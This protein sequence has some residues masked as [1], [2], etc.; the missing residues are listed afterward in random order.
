MPIG[1]DWLD[2]RWEASLSRLS[3]PRP[4]LEQMAAD[5]GGATVLL[6][7][8][9]STIAGVAHQVMGA[10]IE[11]LL[12]GELRGLVIE[13]ALSQLAD[14][15]EAG[16]R[17]RFKLLDGATAEEEQRHW[18][19]LRLD[20][21]RQT[22]L[23]DVGFDSRGLG[24][25][26]EAVRRVPPEPGSVSAWARL[27]VPVRFMVGITQ[28]P[29]KTFDELKRR[30][31]IVLDESWIGPGAD[32]IVVNFG[33]RYAAAG[34]LGGRTITLTEDLEETMDEDEGQYVEADEGLGKLS[35]RLSFDLGERSI[36]LAE[37][38]QLGAGHVF[39]LGRDVRKAV[40]IRANGRS[41]GEGEIVDLDGQIGVLVLRL[42]PTA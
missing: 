4:G 39:D 37:L 22:F 34:I 11:P 36:A 26:A 14:L 42:E 7:T 40:T 19:Q 27:P 18:F 3:G 30:D 8:D 6:R 21:G 32:A 38:M 10:D 25:L 16:T 1:F 35:V 28:L 20:D 2:A 24:F 29:L 41:V 15:L 5:W 9:R 33:Q 31:V 12:D 13:A 17:K 23:A